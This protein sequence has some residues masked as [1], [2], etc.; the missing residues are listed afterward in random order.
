M[1][2]LLLLILLFLPACSLF[3]SND[4]DVTARALSYEV[5]LRNGTS[6][7]VYYFVIGRRIAARTFWGQSLDR[8]YSVAKGGER[9]ISYDEISQEEGGEEQ[10]LVY[11]WMAE[12]EGK[13]ET[14]GRLNFIVVDL[15]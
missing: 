3:S 12:R 9:R 8:T 1:K 2:Y 13:T 11:W 10:V 4:G 14:P 6:E 15:E 7:R 5:I